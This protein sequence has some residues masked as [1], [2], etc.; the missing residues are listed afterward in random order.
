MTSEKDLS[1]HP[2]NEPSEPAEPNAVPDGADDSAAAGEPSEYGD[3]LD[4]WPG[5]GK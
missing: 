5:F 2:K 1:K 3:D 4:K